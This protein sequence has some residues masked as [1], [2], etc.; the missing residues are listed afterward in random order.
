[1]VGIFIIGASSYSSPTN[2]SPPSGELRAL[3]LEFRDSDGAVVK[4]EQ[5]AG[6]WLVVAMA[7]TTCGSTC[8][9]TYGKLLE[10]RKL[11]DA[12]G[13]K[14]DIVIITFD[15]KT[16]T[17]QALNEFRKKKGLSD[18]SWHLWTAPETTIRKFSALLGIKHRQN[19]LSGEIMHDNKIIL[20]DPAG[21][22]QVV[23]EK[24]SSPV[25]EIVDAIRK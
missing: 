15:S 20:F 9:M 21:V 18:A 12:A 19:K 8:P 1:M 16:D 22:R 6:R 17:P 7:Y 13:K 2:A 14:A 5:L 4:F 10:L 24:L 11:L 3:P 25:S 23:L